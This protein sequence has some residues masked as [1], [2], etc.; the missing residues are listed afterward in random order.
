MQLANVV[1][2]VVGLDEEVLPIGATIYPNPS[3]G[4][5]TVTTL[6]ASESITIEVY[7]LLGKRVFN[8]TDAKAKTTIKLEEREGVYLVKITSGDQT[9]VKKVVLRK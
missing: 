4:L 9:S 8:Q 2:S 1:K 3:S 5:F 7:D 6:N